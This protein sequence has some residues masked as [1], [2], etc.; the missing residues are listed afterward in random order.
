VGAKVMLLRNDPDKRWVNGTVAKISRLEEK[1][2]WVEIDG[3][4]HE[5][6]KAAWESR[7]YAFD[8]E[9]G[10]IVEAVVGEFHQFPLRLAWALT[11]HKSQ[12]L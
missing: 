10:K 1:R 5:I 11:I 7:R 12:G 2:V 9:Q 3:D 8:T 6:E 4:E